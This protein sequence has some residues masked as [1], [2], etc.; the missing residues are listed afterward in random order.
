MRRLTSYGTPS[1]RLADSSH[2]RGPPHDEAGYSLADVA[3]GPPHNGRDGGRARST[4][5]DALHI[6]LACVYKLP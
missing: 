1:T 4:V 3:V 5:C 6:D 2:R